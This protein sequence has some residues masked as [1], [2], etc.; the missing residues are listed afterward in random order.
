MC[1]NKPLA[2]TGKR[3]RVN[4]DTI[5]FNKLSI[6]PPDQL[7]YSRTV[8]KIGM[9]IHNNDFVIIRGTNDTWLKV[10]ISQIWIDFRPEIGGILKARGLAK[11][12]HVRA[13]VSKTIYLGVKDR[14]ETETNFNLKALLEM[15]LYLN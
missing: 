12:L 9:H 1:K 5:Y 8:K 3:V 15:T 10:N 2:R 6:L 14:N 4:T 13:C 11:S 7:E